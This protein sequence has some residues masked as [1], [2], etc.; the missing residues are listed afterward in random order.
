M[1]E[2]L[3]SPC[4]VRHF[5]ILSDFDFQ[6]SSDTHRHTRQKKKRKKKKQTH[7]K[8]KKK[9]QTR[10]KND[11]LSA[12]GWISSQEQRHSDMAVLSLLDV[13]LLWVRLRGLKSLFCIHFFL[14]GFELVFLVLRFF[15][16]CFSL[17]FFAL[18]SFVLLL[19]H[20]SC[21]ELFFALN[22]FLAFNF[23]LALN[24]FLVLNSLFCVNFPGFELVYPCFDVAFLVL[25]M[26]SLLCCFLCFELVLSYTLSSLLWPCFTLLESC[27]PYFSLVSLV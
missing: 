18:N 27:L 4:R 25:H 10:K 24:F 16:A 26:F 2:S 12:F 13:L 9:K 3:P 5:A 15:V 22:F 23:F 14:L 7:A 11:W 20:F 6:L 1:S 8:G 21:F 19:N 17:V